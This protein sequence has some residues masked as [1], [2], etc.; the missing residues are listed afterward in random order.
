[1]RAWRL[2][3]ARLCLPEAVSEQGRSRVGTE[4]KPLLTVPLWWG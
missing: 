3:R 4:K 2:T 1:M